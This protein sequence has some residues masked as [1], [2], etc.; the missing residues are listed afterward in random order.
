MLSA[1]LSIA[2]EGNQALM[3]TVEHLER[4]LTKTEE[5]HRFGEVSSADLNDERRLSAKDFVVDMYRS[6]LFSFV[7]GD[8]I[9]SS[10]GI[11]CAQY[12]L[13]LDSVDSIV[14]SLRR[15]YDEELRVLSSKLNTVFTQYRDAKVY[16]TEMN[17]QMEDQVKALF[18][19]GRHSVSEFMLK[20]KEKLRLEV[21]RVQQDLLDT[22][23]KLVDDQDRARTK[24]A[25]IAQDVVN[26]VKNRDDALS[27]L[28]NIENFCHAQR[29]S[30]GALAVYEV[31]LD[32][33]AP[34]FN[35]TL[36]DLVMCV[37]L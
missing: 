21:E 14:N 16:G 8:G 34:A 1:K 28:L 22:E 32:N 12:G 31:L 5:D 27:A 25:K 20:E 17:R 26:L 19:S 10:C 37:T 6:M 36:A 15:C 4:R 24:M 23:Q 29:F 7:S 9:S 2:N 18:R 11:V 35:V 3:A 33:S 13:L 30:L